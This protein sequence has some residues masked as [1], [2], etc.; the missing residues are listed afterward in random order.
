MDPISQMKA[1]RFGEV[2]GTL[3][4]HLAGRQCAW[5]STQAIRL[6]I[7][8]FPLT[9]HSLKLQGPKPFLSSHWECPA[10]HLT[11]TSNVASPHRPIRKTAI[12]LYNGYLLGGIRH[13]PRPSQYIL[14]E[15]GSP[16]TTSSTTHEMESMGGLAALVPAP[17]SGAQCEMGARGTS[18]ASS[19]GSSPWGGIKL[20]QSPGK[21]CL[22]EPSMPRTQPA[23]IYPR[24]PTGHV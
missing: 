14:I 17:D 13:I 19:A 22:S 24:P 16:P 21:S 3:G 7:F 8:P 4:D 20:P 1:R 11:H 9:G 10:H 2:T 5:I 15:Q 12:W 18:Y 6:L 23:G